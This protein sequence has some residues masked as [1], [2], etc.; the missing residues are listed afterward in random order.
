MKKNNQHFSRR[1]FLKRSSL[2]LASASAVNSLG[3]ASLLN[4]S[5]AIAEDN[6]YK[7]LVFIFL[8]GGN[9]AFNMICPKGPGSLRTNYQQVRKNLALPEA[10]LHSLNL[11]T[12][13]QIYGGGTFSDFGMHPACSQLAQ[14]FN[15]QELSVLCN[16]GNLTTPTNREQYFSKEV[17][18]PPQLFSHADQ[19]RQFQSEPN[20]QFRFGWGGRMA[21]L[22]NDYNANGSVSPLISISGLNSFQVTKN[23]VINPYVMGHDGVV[24]LNDFAGRRQNMV[25]DAMNSI[26]DSAHL[27]VQKYRNIFSSARNA[28]DIVNGAFQDAATT[29]AAEGFDYDQIFSAAGAANSKIGKRLK[30]VAKMIAGRQS[31]GNNRPIFF[32]EMK[33]FDSHAN[34]LSDHNGLMTDLSAALKGFRDVLQ[35]QGDYDNV[36]SFVGSEFGRTLTPNGNDAE[37]GTDHAWGGHALVM[38]GMING[39]QFFGT[40]PDLKVNQGLDASDGRG[41]WIPTTATTQASAVIAHWFGVPQ[42]ELPQLFPSLNNFASPFELAANLNFIKSGVE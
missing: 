37:A 2:G 17:S 4:A 6:D 7:A 23:N 39:G 10:E 9:D 8:A 25:E 13:A 12:P 33:G 14:L 34:L 24:S 18:L 21:E 19:Q 15:D 35:A 22:L 27:M 40:H 20:H 38:G 3:L 11:T 42:N 32:V 30:T 31:T 36:L 16:I 41:R 26:D 5:N 1:S 29:A 28:E